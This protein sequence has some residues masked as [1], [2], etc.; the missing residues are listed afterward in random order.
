MG[1]TSCRYCA[2]R[3]RS[4]SSQI[5]KSVMQIGIKFE[6]QA[7]ASYPK[8]AIFPKIR[9]RGIIINYYYFYYYYFCKSIFVSTINSFR[10][11]LMRVSSLDE[12]SRRPAGS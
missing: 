10:P 6:R 8:C 4:E 9:E 7:I 3:W 1:A 11:T 12:V 5:G 2:P